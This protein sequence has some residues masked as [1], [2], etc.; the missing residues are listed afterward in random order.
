MKQAGVCSRCHVAQVLEW[1]A[2]AKHVR[3]GTS[4]QNCHGPSAGHVANERNQVK[5]DRLPQGE[6]AVTALCA[7]C[8]AAG[9][10][11]ST[12]K[13]E[14]QSCHHQHALS[15]PNERELRQAAASAAEEANAAAYKAR[16]A[17]GER[18]VFARDWRQARDRFAEALRARPNDRR[19]FA[20]WRMTERR[21]NPAMPGLEAVG[22]AFDGESGLPLRVRVA[23]LGMEMLL[24]PAGEADIGSDAWPEARPVHA[25]YSEPFYLGKYE[26]TQQEWSVLEPDNPS[27]VKGQ[28]LPVHGISWNDARAW[29][30]KL[31]ARSGGGGFRL[32]SEAEWER[33]A[34]LGGGGDG[35]GLAERAWFRA[36]SAIVDTPGFRESGAYAPR[37]VGLKLPNAAGFFDLQGNAAEW[38]SSLVRPYPYD[39]RDGR[40]SDEGAGGL[41]AVR[42][43]GF[44]DSAEYLDPAFR[45][46]ER[47]S[48][49]SRW[50]GMRLA[51]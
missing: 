26:V 46:S 38:C 12:R 32:P 35:A 44:A 22:D 31:N 17:D 50:T 37:A 43:G 14:C 30:A 16:M 4:C 20:R 23:G 1:S 48:R 7:S 25:F 21:M 49:R 39:A 36:N 24:V 13:A 41:R 27:A 29:I 33:A 5:P 15:N 11:K 42:G 6:P 47:P 51:R 3:A 2:A 8:H 34:R 18:A 45:H 9:C 19:A 10:P 28:T 40:E